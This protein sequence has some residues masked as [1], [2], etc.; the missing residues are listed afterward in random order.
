MSGLEPDHVK[1]KMKKVKEVIDPN[2]R[3]KGRPWQSGDPDI[4]KPVTDLRKSAT[5]SG[6][7]VATIYARGITSTPKLVHVYAVQMVRGKQRVTA[8]WEAP[9]IDGKLTW[10]FTYAGTL[11]MW[12]DAVNNGGSPIIQPFPFTLNSVEMK[13]LIKAP[14]M[15][16]HVIMDDQYHA[17]ILE[18]K[19][20]HLIS[21]T[22]FRGM[23]GVG[24]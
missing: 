14:P 9:V 15:E 10:K 18:D 20:E 3:I 13:R 8:T 4:P 16:R 17:S 1:A 6:W 2:L 24:K 5:A 11:G 19:D 22:E 7:D 23:L 21:E 12:I